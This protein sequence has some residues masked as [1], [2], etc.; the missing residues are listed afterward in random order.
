MS[1][2]ETTKEKVLVAS[3]RYCCLCE[4]FCGIKIEIHHIVQ[5]CE[6]GDDSI[7]N[8]IALCFN[9]HADMKSYDHKHPK[10]TKYRP[11]ELKRRRDDWYNKVKGGLIHERQEAPCENDM[12]T[13]K[14]LTSRLPWDGLIQEIRECS[15]Q[16]RISFSFVD[17][18]HEAENFLKNDPSLFFYNKELTDSLNDFKENLFKLSEVLG[19]HTFGVQT[20]E[21][22]CE[23]PKEYSREKYWAS[24]NLLKSRASAVNESYKLLVRACPQT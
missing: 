5:K 6:Q 12:L 23:V 20:G 8:A 11:S 3:K 13:H 24:I 14:K 2:S 4:E 10:G 17:S 15:F 7:D 9:C 21:Y 16:G 22:Y 1:F 19:T 18:I